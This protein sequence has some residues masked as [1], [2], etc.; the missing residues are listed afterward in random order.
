MSLNCYDCLTITQ[1]YTNLLSGSAAQ[2]L[3]TMH[4]LS[5]SAACHHLAAVPPDSFGSLSGK[6]RRSTPHIKRHA[7]YLQHHVLAALPLA[8]SARHCREWAALP[9]LGGAA[10]KG[11]MA[12]LPLRDGTAVTYLGGAAANSRCWATLQAALPLPGSGGT[13]A[14]CL[15]PIR[16]GTAASYP[17]RMSIRTK[18]N[19]CLV[20]KPILRSAHSQ[21]ARGLATRGETVQITLSGSIVAPPNSRGS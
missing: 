8:A 1:A 17:H 16:G 5:G 10:A 6:C 2:Q 20:P 19:S 12:A 7:A 4:V 9:L 21:N 18:T 11:S 3:T 14:I 15:L 13:A